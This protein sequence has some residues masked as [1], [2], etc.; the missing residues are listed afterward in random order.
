VKPYYER[1]DNIIM[2]IINGANS[3]LRLLGGIVSLLL[4]ILGIL[5][6]FDLVL[7]WSGGYLNQWFNLNFE[8][9]LGSILGYVFYPFTLILGIPPSDALEASRLIGE[10]TF[11]TELVS[12]Q[13]LAQKL[14]D[15]TFLHPRSAII[16]SYALCGFAHVTS[17]AIFVGGVGALA[18]SRLK[19]ITKVGFQALLAATLGCLMTGAVAGTFFSHGSILLGW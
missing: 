7:G 11:A 18:P 3:G 13:H 2:A 5:A 17:L 12:Y 6:L 19:D 1:E 4:A 10:R 14:A 8:W 15:G 9:S 16:T